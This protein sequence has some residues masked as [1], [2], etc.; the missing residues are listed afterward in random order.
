VTVD[1]FSPYNNHVLDSGDLD[2]G[3][4]GPTLL[5]DYGQPD[6]PGTSTHPKLLV[7]GGKA[8]TI[9]LIDR[10]NMGKFGVTDNTVQDCV[11]AVSSTFSVPAYFNGTLYT[12][13]GFGGTAVSWPV[14]TGTIVTSSAQNS[15]DLMGFPG[16]SPSISANG[17]TN[18]IVWLIDYGSQELRAYDATNLA[19]E[20]WTSNQNA[21][22]DALGS[23]VKFACPTPVNG[24]VYVGTANDLV[25]YGPLGSPPTAP[26]NLSASAT[27]P[28]TSS[29]TWTDNA[30]DATQFLIERSG[31]GVTFT[32]IGTEGVN[33][34]TY[35]DSGLSPQTTYYY[36]VR[37]SNAYEGVSY[38]DYTNVASITTPSLYQAYFA[39]YGL[40]DPAVIAP[41]ADPAN[42]GIP[43][44][45][46]YAFSLDPTVADVNGAGLPTTTT[47]NG[48]LTISFVQRVVQGVPSPDLTYTVQV[49]SDL[50]NWSSGP[51]AT[52]QVSVTSLTATTQMVTVSDSTQ[53]SPGSPRF[54][55]V[56]VGSNP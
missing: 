25:A 20:L 33:Q 39:S 51:S 26:T 15:P 50:I 45:L 12:T 9:Y 52:S 23:A 35:S 55:R 19:S 1:Y 49:S 38:S 43:N 42:D 8:G 32:Q 22:R 16:C 34:N 28:A 17:T 31:N 56:S 37:A 27:G 11:A 29:L 46:K 13:P 6:S 3:S 21:T 41:M 48:Y 5:P 36:R 18:G 54:I 24:R 7:G 40:T 44:L 2:L 53:T 47:Q 10:D 14:T 4:G 30:T